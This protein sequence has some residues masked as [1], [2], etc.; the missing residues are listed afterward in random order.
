MVE[1]T[2]YIDALSE[3]TAV[4]L[5]HADLD[6]AL[7]AICQIAARTIPQAESASLTTER[8]GVPHAVSSDAW[9]QKLDELQ[10]HEH[11]GPCLDAMRTGNAFRVEDLA[12]DVRWPS[13]G[14]RAA[15]EGARSTLSLPASADGRIVA[16]LNVYSRQPA[17]F[18][19]DAVT[20][21]QV[22]AAHAGLTAQIS[23]ALQGHRKIAEQLQEA[24]TS[25]AVIEQA[26]GMIML[27]DRIDADAAFGILVAA[28]QRSN[29]KLRAIAEQIV[30]WGRTPPTAD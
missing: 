26:K 2:D 20:V 23:S 18:D 25:R 19:A 9:G 30:E 14:P 12:I 24:M 3:L 8:T 17:A 11:E 10:Y 5:T 27:R 7:V 21:G 22:I 13:Y 6:D 29:T 28:S 15:A 16:A 1:V 4:A